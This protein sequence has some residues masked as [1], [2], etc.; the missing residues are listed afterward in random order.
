MNG[1]IAD[2]MD[3]MDLPDLPFLFVRGKGAYRHIGTVVLVR[4]R[5]VVGICLPFR[6][7]GCL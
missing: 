6:G 1:R 5:V 3:G 2:S 7:K 4:V